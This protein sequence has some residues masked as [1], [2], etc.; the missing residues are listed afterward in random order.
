MAGAAEA[1]VWAWR[2]APR[3]S[4]AMIKAVFFIGVLVGGSLIAAKRNRLPG[5]KC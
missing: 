3:A 2:E 5:D 1:G 4:A